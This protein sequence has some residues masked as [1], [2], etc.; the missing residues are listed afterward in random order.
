MKT[1][2][3]AV[4]LA[5]PFEVG[6]DDAPNLL[7]KTV[8]ALGKIGIDCK[9]TNVIMYDLNTVKDAAQALKSSDADVILICIAT[10]R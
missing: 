4:G 7:N 1:N 5:H 8:E 9:N 2:I 6:F 10:W 3:A